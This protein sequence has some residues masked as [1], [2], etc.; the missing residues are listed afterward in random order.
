MGRGCEFARDALSYL[1][2]SVQL[3]F[4]LLASLAMSEDAVRRFYERAPLLFDCPGGRVTILRGGSEESARAS[5]QG[6]EMVSRWVIL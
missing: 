4:S 3:S 2:Y 5:V 1:L 6:T